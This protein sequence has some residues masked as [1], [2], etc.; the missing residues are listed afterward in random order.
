MIEPTLPKPAW[1]AK[2]IGTTEDAYSAQQM[3][4][5]LHQRN[6][7]A[8]IL[9]QC[10]AASGIIRPVG[11]S[12]PQLLMFGND[13]LEHLIR[14]N[15]PVDKK[16]VM[17]TA[18]AIVDALVADANDGG[19]DLEAGLFGPAF[20]KLVRSWALCCDLV[21]RADEAITKEVPFPTELL[22][23]I[24]ALRLECPSEVVNALEH[25]FRQWFDAVNTSTATLK[26]MHAAARDQLDKI[27]ENDPDPLA[28]PGKEFHAVLTGCGEGV[29][30]EHEPD[31][32]F[33]E[34]GDERMTAPGV[35]AIGEHFRELY[36][37]DPKM[38]RVKV[39]VLND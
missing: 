16:A 11:L 15:P 8:D 26:R 23:A 2:S 22:R 12:G 21:A 13:L 9:G 27:A 7:L 5:A 6:A 24:N 18:S 32:K 33:T 10:I 37:G 4:E 29:L 25:E 31:A 1:D 39:R 30:F 17:T 3:K 36:A 20:S 14:Q 38:K 34:T 35:P 28:P 19:Y